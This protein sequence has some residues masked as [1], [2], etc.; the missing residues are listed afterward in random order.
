MVILICTK[1]KNEKT[2]LHS[3]VKNP[4]LTLKEGILAL[5]TEKVEGYYFAKYEIENTIPKFLWG[6]HLLF[7]V[8]QK[9]LYLI[10]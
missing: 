6:S 2:I 10:N 5:R 1:D 7:L 8:K 4:N 9:K 3:S